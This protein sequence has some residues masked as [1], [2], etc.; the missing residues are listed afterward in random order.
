MYRNPWIAPCDLS[1]KAPIRREEDRS[2]QLYCRS[3][4]SAKGPAILD[5]HYPCSRS[6]LARDRAQPSTGRVSCWPSPYSTF[7]QVPQHARQVKSGS[8][9]R[10]S[11][12]SDPLPTD[13]TAHN[14]RAARSPNA[15]PPGAAPLC[16]PPTPTS[17]RRR[18]Q[19]ATR[20]Q[21]QSTK[22][23]PDASPPV[24]PRPG[25]SLERAGA[26]S[27]LEGDPEPT[28]TRRG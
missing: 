12:R 6:F 3:Y 27:S 21:H 2:I 7:L 8:D 23:S 28:R 20:R 17:G 25:P 26:R 16:L 10:T 11:Q 14:P 9:A 13:Q 18:H 15:A 24:G 5:H 4:H 19:P 22:T 1:L